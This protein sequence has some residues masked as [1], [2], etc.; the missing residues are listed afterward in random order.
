V[1][2]PDLWRPYPLLSLGTA[3]TLVSLFACGFLPGRFPCPYCLCPS[4]VAFCDVLRWPSFSLHE[5][6]YV[7]ASLTDGLMMGLYFSY[8]LGGIFYICKSCWGL[9]RCNNFR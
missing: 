3:P 1:R 5:L 6:L 9:V 8:S 4:W 7:A 2:S